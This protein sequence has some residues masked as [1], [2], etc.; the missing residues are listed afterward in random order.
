M[1]AKNNVRR[2]NKLVPIAGI[3]SMAVLAAS[4]LGSQALTDAAASQQQSAVAKEEGQNSRKGDVATNQSDTTGS[5]SWLYK[6][7]KKY[8]G[9][10]E[11]GILNVRAG[12]GG[13]LVPFTSYFPKNAEIKVGETVVWKNPTLAGEPHTVT[14]IKDAADFPALDVPYIISNSSA[15][16][17]LDP[18]AN[19]DPILIP[20]PEGK[21][22]AVIA[23][24]RAYSPVAVT[25]G[26]AR[27]LAA[28]ETYTMTGNESYVNSGLIWPEGQ[29]PPGL[30]EIT[31]FTVK[32][33]KEGTYD[34]LCILHPWMAGRIVV[35]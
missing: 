6:L 17:P 19:S 8:N 18:N 20:G 25:D 29:V 26:K 11:N 9:E 5:P 24:A 4:I 31:S 12:A 22:V 35:N 30:P 28:N 3:L 32:F 13:P 7:N 34:Y 10:Y 23:N 14:F 27:Y 2:K 15:L 16:V 1:S 33:E 21:T